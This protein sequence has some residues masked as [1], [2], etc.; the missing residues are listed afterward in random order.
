MLVGGGVGFL[1]WGRAIAITFEKYYGIDIAKNF[2]KKMRGI[3]E[4]VQDAKQKEASSRAASPS[5]ERHLCYLPDPP[6]RNFTGYDEEL[7][8]IK[9]SYDENAVTVIEGVRGVGKSSIANRF[10]AQLMEERG[11]S[12]FWFRD[13]DSS[14]D[15]QKIMRAI[16][17]F[18]LARGVRDFD[19]VAQEPSTNWRRKAEILARILDAG[20][21][22]LFLDNFQQYIET[23]APNEILDFVCY[24]NSRLRKTRTVIMTYEKIPAAKLP[25]VRSCTVPLNGVSREEAMRYL[26]NY[27][28]HV[29]DETFQLFYE[30][31]QGHPFAMLSFVSLVESGVI[32]MERLVRRFPQHAREQ[33]NESIGRRVF[34]E[35]RT[36]ERDLLA[37]FSVYRQPV[38]REALYSLFP[39]LDPAKVDRIIDSLI[40]KHFIV[41]RGADRYVFQHHLF[42]EIASESLSSQDAVPCH[43]RAAAYY[44][45]VPKPKKP[46]TD[47]DMRMYLEQR[48][49]LLEAREYEK[50]ADCVAHVAQQMYLMGYWKEA[51]E[52]HRTTIATASGTR[53]GWALHYIGKIEQNRGRYELAGENLNASIELAKLELETTADEDQKRSAQKLLSANIYELG[54]I[55]RER[56]DLAKAYELI[57][58]SLARAKEL[59]DCRWIASSIY[60]LGV[61]MQM[62]NQVEDARRLFYESLG[63]A[64]EIGDRDWIASNTRHLG[65]LCYNERNY[66]EAQTRLEEALK[67]FREIG[68]RRAIA[69]TL[70]NLG[71]VYAA[72][73]MQ[74]EAQTVWGESHAIFDALGEIRGKDVVSRLLGIIG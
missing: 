55:A 29:D 48:H 59:N 31:T 7:K 15:P 70:S 51:E 14:I 53:K 73:Q 42:R 60:Q 5:I 24:I 50:A 37:R 38:E 56:G 41:Q 45:D 58:D 19:E 64:T 49:H 57:S 36:D 27:N 46:T 25:G 30:K 12:P 39:E 1:G 22:A 11:V 33:I 54:V 74:S 52:I 71:Q 16:N 68:H 63:S 72:K 17:S 47:A 35:L 2:F 13:W 18:L 10:A 66:D 8:T 28:I 32:S 26:G 20:N 62:N 43:S 9:G 3:L 34:D 69:W 67:I 4:K 6:L 40:R 23:Q 44:S 21:Y 65:M 61:I